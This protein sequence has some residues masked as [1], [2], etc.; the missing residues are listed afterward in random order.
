VPARTYVALV[1]HPVKARDGSVIT[2]SITNL[3][4]HDIARSARTYNLARYFVVTPVEAQ[5]ALVD[6][7][8]GYWRDGE[9]RE[10]VPQRSEALSLV[11]PLASLEDAMDAVRAREQGRDPILVTTA[12]RSSRTTVGF[13]DA[14]ALLRASDRPALLVLGTGYGLIDATLARAEVHLAPIRPGVYNHLPV[15]GAAAILF[16]RLFGDEGATG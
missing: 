8:T 13:D 7:I 6:H 11:E 3:D 5:R 15:R 1:H 10:R 14:R 16:D 4:V 2:T 12:A 9:G